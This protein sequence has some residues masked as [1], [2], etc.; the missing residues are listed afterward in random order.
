MFGASVCRCFFGE[1]AYLSKNAKWESRTVTGS[2]C[3]RAVSLVNAVQGGNPPRGLRM[4]S[5]D[6]WSPQCGQRGVAGGSLAIGV[7]AFVLRDE[8]RDL[9]LLSRWRER[10]LS[11]P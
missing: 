6:S 4:R 11:N 2:D 7:V 1:R 8:R 3:N 9:A 5:S 10:G